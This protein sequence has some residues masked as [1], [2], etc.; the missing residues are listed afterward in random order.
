MRAIDAK[1]KTCN[2]CDKRQ[3]TEDFYKGRQKGD[4]GQIWEFFDVMC[5]ACRLIYS[6]NRRRD[7]KKLAVEYLGGRC[8]HCKLETDRFEVYDFHHKI[9]EEKDFSI[10]QQTKSFDSIKKELDKCELLCANCHRT[11][12]V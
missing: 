2:K 4:N 11:K 6:S 10:G 5:K 9:P 7:I 12:H 3:S 1:H 8:S